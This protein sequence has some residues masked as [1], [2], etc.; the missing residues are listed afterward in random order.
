MS[1]DEN[2]L[3]DTDSYKASHWLQYPANTTSMYSYLESRGGKFNKTVFFGLQYYLEKYLTKSITRENV[4]EAAAFFA[5]HGLPFNEAGF[6]HIVNKHRGK[7]PIRIKAVPEGSVVPVNNILMSVESTDPECFWI[8]SYLETLLM[9]MW[10]PITV[11]TTSWVAKQIIL[12]SLRKTSDSPEQ[13]IEFKLHDFG[14]RGVSSR[15]SA[16]IGGAAHLVNFLGSDTVAGV[17]M[18]NEIY[19]SEMAAFSIPAAEHSTMTMMGRDGELAQF[20]NM[21]DKFAKPGSLV[22]VVS[23]SYDLW[24]AIDNYW[25]REL[26]KQ[27]INSG[28]TLIVRPDSGEPVE[29]VSEALKRLD[30]KF[31]SFYNTKGY[32]V[33]NNVKLIQG[34]GVNLDSIRQILNKI[35]ADGYSTSNVAFGMGGALLQKL[36]R[37][38]QKFAYKCS[39]ATVDGED[40]DVFKDPITDIGKRSKGGKLD[41]IRSCGGDYQTV[42]DQDHFQSVMRTVFVD[43]TILVSD[44]L[45]EIRKRSNE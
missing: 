44:S 22:A 39:S 27:V 10:Y 30:D 7:F 34:D 6:M 41:L 23:D 40:R 43:G 4:K 15:E 8:V 21:L 1:Y 38:T 33:L 36:D 45:E 13:E 17:C 42:K 9:R 37:D 25:G 19:K 14:S 26:K 16:A 3:L 35:N 28:A 24:N 29:I 5:G 2:L 32:K 12:E 18:A 11:A 31:G 20:K